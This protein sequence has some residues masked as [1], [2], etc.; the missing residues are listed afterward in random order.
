MSKI[1][2]ISSVTRHLQSVLIVGLAPSNR[3]YKVN[4][5]HLRKEIDLVPETLCVFLRYWT[6]GEVQKPSIP[7]WKYATCKSLCVAYRR[8]FDWII[9]LIAPFSIYTI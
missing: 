1:S 8:G 9:G 4:V 2:E 5:S 3:T 7:G 6:M